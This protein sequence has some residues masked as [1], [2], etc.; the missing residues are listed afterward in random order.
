MGGYNSGR[1]SGH[2][3][4]E[5]GLA[6]DVRRLLKRG[7]FVPGR[8]LS[9]SIQWIVT[10]TGEQQ[11][12]IA[13]ESD[14]SPGESGSVRLR[15]AVNGKQ[16]EYAVSLVTTECNYGGRRWWFICPCSGRRCA[17]LHLPPGGQ[18]FAARK[19]YKLSYRSQREGPLD[20]SHSRLRRIYSGLGGDYGNFGDPPPRRPKG[21]RQKTYDG[22]LGRLDAAEEL[23]DCIWLG[24]ASR[25][26]SR[27]R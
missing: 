13:Y 4:A 21:M 22:L 1:H 25:F 10:R 20:R 15:Y 9:G 26:L 8:R 24:G 27:R 11:A 17:K 2:P 14:L 19:A 23:H 18:I 6:L 7:A 3:T 5:S 12:V 16:Q